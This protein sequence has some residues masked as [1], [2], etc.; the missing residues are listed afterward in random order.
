MKTRIDH[1][2]IHAEEHGIRRRRAS[3]WPLQSHGYG[4]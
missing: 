1:D 3:G 4:W 2:A